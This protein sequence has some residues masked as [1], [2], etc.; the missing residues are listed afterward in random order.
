[1][2]AYDTIA[3]ATA[4]AQEY[5]N[6]NNVTVYVVPSRERFTFMLCDALSNAIVAVEP[7]SEDEIP[8]VFENIANHL[9]SQGVQPTVFDC[10]NVAQNTVEA[11]RRRRPMDARLAKMSTDMHDL[12][13]AD[14]LK[15]AVVAYTNGREYIAQIIEGK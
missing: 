4:K 6:E 15:N 14:G 13:H 9:R 8:A 10:L 5:A 3:E 1:M 11:L 7:M 2:A 12:F